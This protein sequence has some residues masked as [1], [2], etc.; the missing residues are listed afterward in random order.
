MG[1]EVI[2]A[3]DI[4]GT[5]KITLDPKFGSPDKIKAA[6]RSGR[7]ARHSSTYLL[8]SSRFR[9]NRE[10]RRRTCLVSFFPSYYSAAMAIALRK[11]SSPVRPSDCLSDCSERGRLKAECKTQ[12]ANQ[13]ANSCQYLI[14]RIQKAKLATLGH[15]LRAAL[16]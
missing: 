13:S 7:P 11:S 8:L 16:V 9:T 1:E 14:L 15:L 5:S 12:V 10:R 3:N 2:A 4:R 6:R